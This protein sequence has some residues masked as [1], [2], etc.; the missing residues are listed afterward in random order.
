MGKKK[1][2]ILH[3]FLL[4]LKN[5]KLDLDFVGD[6]KLLKESLSNPRLGFFSDF[7]MKFKKNKPST[8]AVFLS[9]E[10][11]KYFI[12]LKSVKKDK[13]VKRFKKNDIKVLLIEKRNGYNKKELNIIRKEG[14]AI[15]LINNSSNDIVYSAINAL[16]DLLGKRETVYGVLVDV[17]EQGILIIGKSGIGKSEC[18]LE[19]VS[20]NHRLVADDIVEIKRIGSNLIGTSASMSD[21]YLEIRGL[22]IIDIKDFFGLRAVADEKKIDL[23]VNLV[24]FDKKKHFTRLGVDRET[25]RVLGIDIPM[26]TIPISPGK[27]IGTIIEVIAKNEYAK[28]KGY[29][30]PMKLTKD[31]IKK[32]R[33]EIKRNE[34]E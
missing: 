31:L 25:Y 1:V 22:G 23:V 7:A 30:T 4:K 21:N 29:N 11:F 12:E 17:A 27:N 26:Y 8:D 10:D 3:E 19:L 28:E 32:I 13:I 2:P 15:F 14:I 18:A 24:L 33:K 16:D 20:K 5:K 34:E 9:S 6:E